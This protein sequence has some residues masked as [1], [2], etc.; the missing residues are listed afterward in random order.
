MRRIII[1]LLAVL[2]VL[3]CFAQTAIEDSLQIEELQEVVIEAPRV[4]R[5]S[6]MD[7]YHPSKSAVEH[8]ANGMQLLNN[9]MIPTLRSTM[10]FALFRLP[11]KACKSE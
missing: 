7:V 9:L 2:S 1:V 4:I 10:L 5:K 3:I 8:S 6:D 11:D